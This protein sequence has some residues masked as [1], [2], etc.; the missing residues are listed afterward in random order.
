MKFIRPGFYKVTGFFFFVLLI[1]S[2]SYSQCHKGIVLSSDSKA[3]IGY[4]NVGIVGKNVGTVADGSGKFT[5][6]LEN[7]YDQDSLRFSMIG[8]ESKSF[9]IGHFKK[10]P[11]NDIFLNPKCYNL[12]EIQVVYPKTRDIVLGD[13]VTTDVLR[14]GF[15]DN[16]LG[17]EL[18]IRFQ[19]K[20]KVKLEDLN[21]NIATCTYDSVKYRLNIYEIDKN[22]EYNNILSEPIYI[23]FSKEM[24]N[25]VITLDLKKY[26]LIVNGDVLISL[27]LFKNLG[28]GRLLFHT[29]YFTGYTYH[30]KCSMAD[31][32][33]APGVIGMYVHGKLIKQ[34]LTKER[35]NFSE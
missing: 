8:Y 33:A 11:V 21:L 12:Q 19:T 25:D 2:V 6:E 32:I 1:P 23:T 14:S 34:D 9:L 3:P 18:G 26:S 7:I 15:S 30:R 13:P 20:G 29:Q 28:E 27:E 17:S 22:D 5:I 16:D 4:V 10:N 35:N 24:I 31:W